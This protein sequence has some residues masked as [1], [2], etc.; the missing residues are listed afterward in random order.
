MNYNV[1]TILIKN[2]FTFHFVIGVLFNYQ[3]EP[4]TKAYKIT[5]QQLCDKEFL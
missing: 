5:V 1:T 4:N 3:N 2:H